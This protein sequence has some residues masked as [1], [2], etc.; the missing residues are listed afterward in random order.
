MHDW[1][2]RRPD[3]PKIHREIIKLLAEEIMIKPISDINIH[4]KLESLMKDEPIMHWEQSQPRPI[5]W[6]RKAVSAI[7]SHVFRAA[8]D[9]LKEILNE[10]VI[11]TDG[12][13][14]DEISGRLRLCQNV[15]GFFENDLTKQDR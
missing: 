9:R 8:K 4:I 3:A 1:L 11:Y 7:F 14:P 6:Q 10:K 15:H 5:M 13:R 12:L 2:K